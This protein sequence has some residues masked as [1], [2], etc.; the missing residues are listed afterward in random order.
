LDPPL[1]QERLGIFWQVI[2]LWKALDKIDK[3]GILGKLSATFSRWRT[4][5]PEVD[6]SWEQT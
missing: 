1:P 5:K 2:A 3:D 4:L 6:G